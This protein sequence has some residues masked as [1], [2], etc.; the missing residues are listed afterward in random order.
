MKKQQTIYRPNPD[1]YNL[2]NMSPKDQWDSLKVLI[3]TAVA[4]GSGIGWFLGL[5][6]LF[7]QH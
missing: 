7:G 1:K 5:I 4:A 6:K 3:L 2:G